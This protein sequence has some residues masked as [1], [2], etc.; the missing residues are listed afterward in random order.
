MSFEES[1]KNAR[2]HDYHETWRNSEEKEQGESA[3]KPCMSRKKTLQHSNIHLDIK[4][5]PYIQKYYEIMAQIFTAGSVAKL[6]P[7]ITSN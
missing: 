4:T 6:F 5:N 1:I 3:D 2:Y 7:V